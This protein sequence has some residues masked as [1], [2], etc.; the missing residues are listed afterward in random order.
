LDPSL[1][2]FFLCKPTIFASGIS[3]P[4]LPDGYMNAHKN[5]SKREGSIRER[6]SP[7]LILI[8]GHVINAQLNFPNH[9][10]PEL[11]NQLHTRSFAQ[12]D[13][14]L[15]PSCN[16]SEWSAQASSPVFVDEKKEFVSF[17]FKLYQ[18]E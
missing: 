5:K 15:H 3:F 16:A 11:T 1:P 4:T 18:R 17:L 13:A 2:A 6:E 7:Q 14:M 10:S 8:L 12:P 9:P